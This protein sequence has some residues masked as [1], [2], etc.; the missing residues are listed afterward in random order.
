MHLSGTHSHSARATR[1][2]NA[3]AYAKTG[4]HS[5]RAPGARKTGKPLL[6]YNMIQSYKY[7]ALLD[8][9]KVVKKTHTFG[10]QKNKQAA[11]VINFDKNMIAP[12]TQH[13]GPE[14]N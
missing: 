8:N 9:M 7:D 5:A 6:G 12:L 14:N 11:L 10:Y 2:E 4:L 1:P 13:T 3:L